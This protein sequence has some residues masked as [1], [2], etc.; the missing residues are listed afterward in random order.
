MTVVQATS[1][2]LGSRQRV[3]KH[4]NTFGVFDAHGDVASRGLG[5]QGLYHLDTRH[6]SRFVLR[7]GGKRPLLLSSTVTH[8]NLLLAVDLANPDLHHGVDLEKDV[9]HLF[10]GRFLRP[11]T[12]HEELRFTNYADRRVEVSCRLEF[13]AD[14]RDLFEIRGARRTE[15]GERLEPEVRVDGVAAAYRGLDGIVRRTRLSVTGP[16]LRPGPAAVEFPVELEPRS[17]VGRRLTVRCE[18]GEGGPNPTAAF[19]PPGPDREYDALRRRART[20]LRERR[21][22]FARVSTADGRFDAWWNRSV[23][24]LDVLLTDLPTGPYPFAGIPWFSAPFGRDGVVAA[25]EV[26]WLAPFVA[27]GVLGYLAATQARERDPAHDAEPGKILHEARAGEMANRGEV[28]FGRYYGSVDSTPLFVLLAAAY[29]RRTGDE[30]CLRS[31]LPALRRALAWMAED[32]D[33]D[34]D[35]LLEYQRKDPRGLEN[36]S[37]KDSHD[38]MFHADGSA[39]VGPVAPVEV[40]G[41]AYRARCDV[42]PLL[43]RFGREEEAVREERR[44]ERLRAAVEEAFWCEELGTYAMALDGR[45]RPLA[46]RSSNAGHLLFSGL[47][48]PERARRCADVLMGAAMYSGW[49]I[50]TV[51]SGEARYN[52]M[53]YHNGSVWPH[54]NAMVALGLSRYGLTDPCCRLLG[55]FFDLGLSVSLHRLPELFCGFHRR[56][57]EAPVTYPVACS[58]QA[59]A[60]GSPALFLQACLGLSVDAPEGAVRLREPRLP[61]GLEEV[62]VEGLRVAGD[63]LDLRLRRRGSGEVDV[64]VTRSTGGVDVRVLRA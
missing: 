47:P 29:W 22:R 43:R 58:P 13:A 23:D 12:L 19:D 40:Q 41:Y 33:P 39:A 55:A 6:L 63:E 7:L 37:W 11:G 57:G 18:Q 2:P 17:V 60:A 21:R 8:G 45:K 9:L 59:W 10:R 34:G 51:G 52:P 49:G 64:E 26:L 42:A 30:E 44:A 56:P 61:E 36:Q 31:L 4:A 25:L 20:E 62:T 35:G 14:F 28:P 24:D 46:V 50:R 38:S 16:G 15:R 27:R 5:E 54:D 53:S 48:D 32:G 1:Q 3:L